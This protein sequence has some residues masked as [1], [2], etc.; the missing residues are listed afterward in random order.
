VLFVTPCAPTALE[1]DGSAEVFGPLNN[2][3]ACAE[4][5]T[6]SVCEAGVNV[7]CGNA[8]VELADTNANVSGC[9]EVLVALLADELWACWL[10]SAPFK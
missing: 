6:D 3:A 8:D 9:R 5:A 2:P 1:L 4:L 10:S 7:S